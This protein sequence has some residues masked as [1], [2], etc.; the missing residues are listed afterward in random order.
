MGC[1]FARAMWAATNGAPPV[2]GGSQ[3]GK[4]G[5]C[6]RGVGEKEELLLLLHSGGK[7]G[8]AN[9]S[10][11]F[12]PIAAKGKDMRGGGERERGRRPENAPLFSTQSSSNVEKTR[13]KKEKME[14]GKKEFLSG[15][16]FPLPLYFLPLP[17]LLCCFPFN[18]QSLLL[19]PLAAA[20]KKNA[21]HSV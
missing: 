9:L 15:K 16:N 11:V 19:P 5:A 21:I 12:S 2:L 10:R 6:P 4:S 18:D 13:G 8:E 17:L 3:W 7:G 1:A 20:A 14:K